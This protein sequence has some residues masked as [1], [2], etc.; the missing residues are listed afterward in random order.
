VVIEFTSGVIRAF[1]ERGFLTVAHPT[2]DDVVAANFAMLTEAWRA[3]VRAP[4]AESEAEASSPI[5][6]AEAPSPPAAVLPQR[7]ASPPPQAPEEDPDAHRRRVLE[8][9]ARVQS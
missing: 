5:P 4:E 3:G 1:R 9:L 7:S 2:F 6:P 8:K